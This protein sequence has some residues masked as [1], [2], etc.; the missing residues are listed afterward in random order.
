MTP[1][2]EPHRAAGPV[3]LDED[4]L[5][6]AGA[7]WVA[8]SDTEWRLV[9]LMLDHRDHLVSRRQLVEAGWPGRSVQDTTLNVMMKRV[10]SRLAP[11]GL[12]VT[13]VRGRGFVLSASPAASHRH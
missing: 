8:L 13:T 2:V 4:G 12:T 6:H 3:G 9:A 1:P 7:D 5:L 11:L 10:R